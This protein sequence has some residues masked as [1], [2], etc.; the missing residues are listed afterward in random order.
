MNL[1]QENKCVVIPLII[2]HMCH[3]RIKKGEPY[4]IWEDHIYCESCFDTYME[5]IDG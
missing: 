5:L 3:E 1:M 4:T 2:C